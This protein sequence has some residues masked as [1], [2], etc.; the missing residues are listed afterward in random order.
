M[1]LRISAR[2]LALAVSLIAGANLGGCGNSEQPQPV[3]DAVE[4]ADL[5]LHGGKIVTV[6][7][8]LGEQQAIA[9]RG[10]TIAAVGSDAEIAPYIGA[11]TTVVELNGRLAIPGFIE[12]HGHFMGFG[13]ARQILDLNDV[14]NWDEIVNKVAVAADAAG[15]GEWIFGRGWHQEKWDRVPQNAVDG[16]PKNDSL[17]NVAPLNPVYL[18]HA[19]GHAAFANDAALQAAGID[20]ETPDPD[21]GTIVRASDGTAT[22]LL[23]ENAQGLAE[24]A[25]RAF[26]SRMTAEQTQHMRRARVQLA[27]QEA[28][29]NGITSFHDAGSSF[30]IIDFLKG[31]ETEGKLPVRLYVMVRGQSNDELDALLPEYR[32]LAEGNDFLT[33]RAIKRQI[34]GALGSHGA[35][36]LEPYHDLTSTRGLVL[37]PVNEIERTAQIAVKHG[38]Q[39]N[40]HAIGTRAN[41]ETLDI[42][43]RVWAQEKADGKALRWRVEHAQHIHP[44]DVPLESTVLSQD[45]LTIA[46]ADI[47]ATVVDYTFVGGAMGYAR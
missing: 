2:I 13:R 33:V 25:I 22:G 20:A 28:L 29:A 45:I 11:D 46:E 21:G 43:E 5:V 19:S 10:H 47:P 39:V 17:N 41:R 12:G 1:A 40:T 27:G 3:R 42:Y 26:E 35:W 30:A 6:D 14:A 8:Q 9:V 4:P 34:D 38:F 37:E 23:R 16:V 32:M 7:A 18:G 31:L 15:P 36:L 44:T 24:T